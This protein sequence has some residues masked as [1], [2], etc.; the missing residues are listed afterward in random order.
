MCIAVLFTIVQDME[1]TYMSTDKW[2]DKDVVHTYTLIG[3]LFNHKKK[4]SFAAA[5]IDLE[6]NLLSEVSKKAKCK[7]HTI[8]F[9]CGI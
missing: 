5:W 3:I 6:I 2:M 1:S 9:I 4:K 8:S 7:Y